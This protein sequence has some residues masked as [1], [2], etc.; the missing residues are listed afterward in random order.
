M[1]DRRLLTKTTKSV[2][3]KILQMHKSGALQAEIAIMCGVSKATVSRRL[4]PPV[5]RVEKKGIRLDDL[6]KPRS[7]EYAK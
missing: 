3:D 2:D 7:K 1:S 6:W 5:Q 4:N